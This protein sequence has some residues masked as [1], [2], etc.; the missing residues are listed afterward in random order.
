MN[1]E[2]GSSGVSVIIQQINIQPVLE[3]F[4][5][6]LQV[7]HRIVCKYL[8]WFILSVTC[9]GS[10]PSVVTASGSLHK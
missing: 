3:G 1:D 8:Q 9:D 2:D 5:E 7:L 6:V 4:H 10:N